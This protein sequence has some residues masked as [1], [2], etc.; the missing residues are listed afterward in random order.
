MDTTH[1]EL[2]GITITEPFTW[3]TNWTIAAFSFYFGHMLFHAKSGDKQAKYWSMFFVFMGIASVTGG[4][5][6][7]FINY[8]GNNFHL[9]AWIFTG[10]AVFGAQLS[11]LEIVKDARVYSPLKWFIIIEVLVMFASVIIYQSFESVRINSALG[12]VGIVLP[13]Q[14]YGYKFLGMRRNGIIAIGIISNVVPALIAANK[15]S[16]NRWFNF[17]DVSHIFMIGCFYIIYLGAKKIAI[18]NP[19]VLTKPTA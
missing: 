17:N 16:Y 11:A 15:Y 1:I 7:G 5:A 2:F 19:L 4:T 10:I 3:L 13:I 12:L 18:K 14:L 8:V 6:H 9:A